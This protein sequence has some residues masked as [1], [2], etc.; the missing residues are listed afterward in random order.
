MPTRPTPVMISRA[1]NTLAFLGVAL[2][3]LGLKVLMME[4]KMLICFS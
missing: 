3:S 1:S 4:V 2:A